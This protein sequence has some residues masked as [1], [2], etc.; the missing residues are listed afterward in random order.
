MRW[1]EVTTYVRDKRKSWSNVLASR[2]WVLTAL[3]T[4][5]IA[6]LATLFVPAFSC[7][8][9]RSHSLFFEVTGEPLACGNKLQRWGTVGAIF[10]SVIPAILARPVLIGSVLMSE[11][12]SHHA[13][14]TMQTKAAVWYWVVADSAGLWHSA[15]LG[16][17]WWIFCLGDALGTWLEWRAVSFMMAFPP[18]WL[19]TPTPRPRRLWKHWKC[20]SLSDYLS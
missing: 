3:F 10:S 8:T 11:P 6:S 13:I 5:I 1:E 20:P 14:F 2:V 18:R 19:P 16:E 7:A 17:E 12:I 15:L 4:K 9:H